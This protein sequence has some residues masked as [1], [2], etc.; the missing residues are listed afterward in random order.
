M[1]GPS[2]ELGMP[3]VDSR[4]IIAGYLR[5]VLPFELHLS[6]LSLHSYNYILMRYES[7]MALS[8]IHSHMTHDGTGAESNGNSIDILAYT[9]IW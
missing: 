5:S 6:T 8:S 3:G 4:E 7:A 2:S 9:Q 1:R